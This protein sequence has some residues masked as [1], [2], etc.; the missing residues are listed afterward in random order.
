MLHDMRPSSGA[1]FFGLLVL[2]ATAVGQPPTGQPPMGQP[3]MGQGEANITARA[4]V[5]MEVQSGPR[6]SGDK[7]GLIGGAIGGRLAGIRTCYREVS[8]A[9]PTVTGDMRIAVMLTAGRVRF[10]VTADNVND[11]QLSR[12]TMRE[13]RRSELSMI[14]PPGTAYIILHFTNSAAAGVA[15]TQQRRAREDAAP[16]HRNA[17]GRLESSGQTEEG[18]VRF[19]IVGGPRASEEQVQAV[20]STMRSTI[21]TF[22]DCRR[23]ASRRTSP[24]GE[25]RLVL[26][27]GGNGRGRARTTRSTVEDVR[28]QRCVERALRRA[29]FG[30]EG[31]GRTDIYIT[32][33]DRATP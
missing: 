19:R 18:E 24:N 9:R 17:D 30:R 13:L 5:R 26:Q 15:E 4:D 33:A 32:F 7:L 8:A 16:V 31:R 25:I 11:R 2:P 23:K 20:Q 10:D 1:I 6:T 22:L 3:P 14:Q 27:V 21:P 29:R 28:G 12:C